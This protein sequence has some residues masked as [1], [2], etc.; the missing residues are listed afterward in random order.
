MELDGNPVGTVAVHSYDTAN[1]PVVELACLHVQRSHKG[2]GHGQKL[3]AFAET[4]AR[5]RG[6]TRILALSTQAS[7]FFNEKLGYVIGSPEDL[8]AER[9]ALY[10]KSGRNSKV[11]Y[12]EV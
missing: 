10:D 7:G 1:G 8:P 11:L 9:R 3:V 6:A 2:R 4:Q 12:K 5:Q